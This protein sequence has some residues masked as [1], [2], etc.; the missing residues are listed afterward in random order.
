MNP[1]QPAGIRDNTFCLKFRIEN[2]IQSSSFSKPF[3]P[4][5]SYLYICSK[6][7]VYFKKLAQTWN[8]VLSAELLVPGVKQLFY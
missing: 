8:R 6:T 4:K 1:P 3:L 2:R 7:S 5:L